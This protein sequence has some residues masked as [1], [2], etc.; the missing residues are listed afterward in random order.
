MLYFF[1]S[2]KF[3]IYTN[4]LNFTLSWRTTLLYRRVRKERGKDKK[5]GLAIKEI[6]KKYNSRREWRGNRPCRKR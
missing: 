6:K 4:F 3:K 5:R 2:V 1:F